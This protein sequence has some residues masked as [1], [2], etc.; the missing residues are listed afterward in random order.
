MRNVLR[1][2]NDPRCLRSTP[3]RLYLARLVVDDQ[4]R[5]V[6]LLRGLLELVNHLD[7]LVMHGHAIVHAVFHVLQFDVVRIV[8]S[9]IALVLLYVKLSAQSELRGVLRRLDNPGFHVG[10]VLV[11]HRFLRGEVHWN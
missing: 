1:A 11:N 9:R 3:S 7:R 2:T 8:Q 10:I 4:E 6:D 5:I